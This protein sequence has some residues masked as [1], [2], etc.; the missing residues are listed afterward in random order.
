MIYLLTI[1]VISFINSS[2]FDLFLSMM[3]TKKQ[4]KET[5]EKSFVY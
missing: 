4:T 2:Y 3:D 5:Y 1:V